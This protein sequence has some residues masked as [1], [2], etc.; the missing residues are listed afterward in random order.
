[1]QDIGTARA[2]LAATPEPRPVDARPP[3]S[4][5]RAHAL[6][7]ALGL[8]AFLASITV[9]VGWPWALG[10]G[11]LIVGVG[12]LVIE[13]LANRPPPPP[14]LTGD[15]VVRLATRSRGDR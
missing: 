5:G 7:Q 8:A 14:P 1:M 3:T 11:G 9:L 4:T 10:V 6:A 12:S 15:D 2:I 13:V